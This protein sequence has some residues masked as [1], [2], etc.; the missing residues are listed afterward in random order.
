MM[1]DITSIQEDQL[2]TTKVKLNNYVTSE[3]NSL[4]KGWSKVV[5]KQGKPAVCKAA[6]ASPRIAESDDI[7]HMLAAMDVHKV[8]LPKIVA[9]DLNRISVVVGLS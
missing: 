3:T 6:Q 4:I 7:L 5:N 1:T 8:D 9:E 2:H